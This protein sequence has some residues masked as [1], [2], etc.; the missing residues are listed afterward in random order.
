MWSNAFKMPIQSIGMQNK[1]NFSWYKP[2]M[3]VFKKFLRI[4]FSGM[5]DWNVLYTSEC[6]VYTFRLCKRSKQIVFFSS[7]SKSTIGI[8]KTCLN[9]LINGW[10]WFNHRDYLAI[11]TY[12]K[13]NTIKKNCHVLGKWLRYLALD[14]SPTS[15]Q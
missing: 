11:S 1:Y 12:N 13:Q 9:R 6:V 14:L 10:N 7:T 3:I 5:P 2:L 8:W 15:L 4:Y